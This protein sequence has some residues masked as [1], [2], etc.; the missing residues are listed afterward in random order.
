MAWASGL[1]RNDHMGHQLTCKCHRHRTGG[2]G[3][4]WEERSAKEMHQHPP[5][6]CPDSIEAAA[7]FRAI[8]VDENVERHLDSSW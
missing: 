4:T 6:K 7:C 2:T 5:D 3:E 1:Q 8:S